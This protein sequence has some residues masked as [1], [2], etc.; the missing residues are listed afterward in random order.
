MSIYKYRVFNY[1]TKNF[2]F[3]TTSQKMNIGEIKTLPQGELQI[4]RLLN[5]F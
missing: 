3:L 2:E 1:T 4:F 5:V